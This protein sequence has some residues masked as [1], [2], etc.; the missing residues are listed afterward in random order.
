MKIYT[1]SG[2]NGETGLY[3]GQRVDK[4]DI[5]VEAYGTIDELNAALGIAAS[6]AT[7]NEVSESIHALQQE[8]F[9]A[10]WDLATP[11]TADIPRISELNVV[12]LESEIDRYEAE[13]PPL[14]NFILPGGAPT[15][16]A[17]HLARC[18]CRRAE[19]RLVTLM[20]EYDVNPQVEIYLNRVSDHLFVLARVAAHRAHVEEVIWKRD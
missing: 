13:L 2:D 8:L 11:A 15:S 4:D 14:K 17:L 1:R 16:S 3:G 18:I 5:R 19:R 6:F 10:C 20:H 12:R 7:D 9:S